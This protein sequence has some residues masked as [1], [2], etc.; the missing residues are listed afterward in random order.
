MPNLNSGVLLVE[1]EEDLRSVMADTLAD[2]G[3]QLYQAGTGAEALALFDS[4][5][6]AIRLV[7]VDL[8]L[9][10]MRGSELVA[11]LA[12]RKP[13]LRFLVCSGHASPVFASDAP[14]AYL[15]KPFS[16]DE[17]VQSISSQFIPVDP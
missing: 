2:R 6:D 15:A 7:V 8:L 14:V 10:D 16:V 1:D 9:P 13:D 4:A 3:Y 11:A 17:L 12:L 5:S